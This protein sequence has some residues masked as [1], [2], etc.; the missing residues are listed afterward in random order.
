MRTSQIQ[1]K[2]YIQNFKNLALLFLF[3]CSSSLLA[4]E[5]REQDCPPLLHEIINL[6][7]EEQIKRLYTQESIVWKNFTFTY[8]YPNPIINVLIA[9]WSHNQSLISQPDPINSEN[10]TNAYTSHPDDI[11]RLWTE[12]EKRGLLKDFFFAMV[13]SPRKFCVRKGSSS[14]RTE[15][16]PLE[17]SECACANTGAYDRLITDR[18]YN[19]ENAMI[20]DLRQQISNKDQTVRIMSLGCGDLLQETILVGRF[21]LEGFSSIDMTL[22]NFCEDDE[23]FQ[24]CRDFFDQTFPEVTISWT[25][26]ETVS[27]ISPKTRFNLIYAIDF[28]DLFAAYEKDDLELYDCFNLIESTHPEES[29]QRKARIDEFCTGLGDVIQ[30]RNL[31]TSSGALF[32]GIGGQDMR[33][34]SSNDLKLFHQD[35]YCKKEKAFHSAPLDRVHILTNIHHPGTV[36]P[37][38]V[39]LLDKGCESIYLTMEERDYLSK[40]K[41]TLNGKEIKEDFTYKTTSHKFMEKLFQR[42][43][44]K[45]KVQLVDD[46]RPFIP[47]SHATFLD[48]DFIRGDLSEYNRAMH[49]IILN[50]SYD[51]D[52][53][54]D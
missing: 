23:V 35:D 37:L 42:F 12:C 3:L 11:Q 22:V 6:P 36:F 48:I 51:K 1:I 46:I 24:K 49:T 17:A 18:R 8:L 52:E 5:I 2:P 34:S 38:L 4:N 14:P 47:G 39:T 31:L 45:I 41:W 30:A 16:P 53:N 20:Q 9:E 25:R 10:Q 33:I 26:V 7:E 43:S 27:D 40:I 15:F 28:D 19:F 21:I 54:K 50:C 13:E 29:K 32:L 44:H